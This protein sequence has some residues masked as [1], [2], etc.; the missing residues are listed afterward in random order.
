MEEE[1]Y[2]ESIEDM[3]ELELGPYRDDIMNEAMIYGIELTGE[4][5]EHA[6]AIVGYMQAYLEGAA[7]M[8]SMMVSDIDLHLNEKTHNTEMVDIIQAQQ[9]TINKLSKILFKLSSE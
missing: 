2:L 8:Y 3:N 4:P 9:F 1:D 7:K 6:D 5:E